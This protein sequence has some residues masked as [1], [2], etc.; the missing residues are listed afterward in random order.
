[1]L[2]ALLPGVRNLERA[3]RKRHVS[4]ERNTAV[5]RFVG[6][7]GIN[8]GGESP[9]DLDEPGTSIFLRPYGASSLFR[10]GHA[11]HIREMCRRSIN[12]MAAGS[13]ARCKHLASCHFSLPNTYKFLIVG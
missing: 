10:C 3:H 9:I 7:R 1:M 4:C 8:F 13:N 12:D 2:D 5:F 6:Y 11:Q